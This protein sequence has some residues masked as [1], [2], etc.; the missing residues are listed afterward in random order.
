M[1]LPTRAVDNET[2][3]TPSTFYLDKAIIRDILK[4]ART[5]PDRVLYL[6]TFLY[7]GSLP[8]AMNFS[9]LVL[10]AE[11]EKKKLQNR[12]T[13]KDSSFYANC[14]NFLLKFHH[15]DKRWYKRVPLKLKGDFK[16]VR[17]TFA[18]LYR[19]RSFFH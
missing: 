14:S 11:R 4:G 6:M 1:R 2:P 5:R 7:V 8:M 19:I 17:I 9:N 16:L 13:K 18:A 10:P 3:L 12:T 15:L